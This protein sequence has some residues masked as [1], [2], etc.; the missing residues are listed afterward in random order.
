MSTPTTNSAT[1]DAAALSTEFTVAFP[2]FTKAKGMLAAQFRVQN[3]AFTMHLFTGVTTISNGRTATATDLSQMMSHPSA[4]IL[5]KC[6]F[7]HVGCF[8]V[9]DSTAPVKLSLRVFRAAG[10][11]A[12]TANGTFRPGGCA[13]IA[14]FVDRDIALNAAKADG[15]C[16]V[17]RVAA[18]AAPPTATDADVHWDALGG[19]GGK[20]SCSSAAAL[21]YLRFLPKDMDQ[22]DLRGDL[23]DALA[24]GGGGGGDFQIVVVAAANE[25]GDDDGGVEAT[26]TIGVHKFVL[27][28]RSPVLR[29]MLAST[30]LEAGDGRMKIVGH[31][32]AAIRAFVQFLYSDTCMEETL[33]AHGWELLELADRY[34]VPAL[35]RVCESWH[36]GRICAAN[37]IET[38]QRADAYNAPTLKRKAIEYVAA[39][40]KSALGGNSQAALRDLGAELLSEVVRAIAD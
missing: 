29:A 8:V 22:K 27:A 12:A 37:A 7:G 36:S 38:L 30:M 5:A 21:A 3:Y 23:L 19:V 24:D 28:A 20:P 33:A 1:D 13:S 6:V 11:K 26:S 18:N 9:N 40:K 17:L 39:N 15:G 14:M 35:R 34:E 4:S 32:V 2:N 10:K 16:L 25:G 31:S